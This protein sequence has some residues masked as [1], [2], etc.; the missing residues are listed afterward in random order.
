MATLAERLRAE[1]REYAVIAGYLYVCLGGLMIYKTAVLRDAGIAFAPLG[2]ALV[3]ALLLGKFML[4]GQGVGIGTRGAPRPLVIHAVRR[5][6]LLAALL[7]SLAV[8]EEL[9]VGWWRGRGVAATL[10]ELGGDPLLTL[11][12]DALV[13]LLVLLPLVAAQELARALGPGALRRL[14]RGEPVR[15]DD[16][17]P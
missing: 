13:L 11:F 15:G 2:I 16:A 14:L 6:L 12:A 3:K 17:G 7:M 1:L 5:S 8:V 4:I 10:A 9:L